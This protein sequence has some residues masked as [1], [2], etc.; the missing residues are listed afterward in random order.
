M[1]EAGT[2]PIKGPNTGMMSVILIM[3]AM[4]TGSFMPIIRHPI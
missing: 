2:V 1:R 3:T 4:S